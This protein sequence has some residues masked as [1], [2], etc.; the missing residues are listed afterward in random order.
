MFIF[1]EV[2]KIAGFTE[3]EFLEQDKS[4]VRYES[5][6]KFWEVWKNSKAKIM[7]ILGNYI[8]NY[9]KLR[10]WLKMSNAAKKLQRLQKLQSCTK[11]V[12][13]YWKLENMSVILNNLKS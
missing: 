10:K 8:D 13:N 4:F 12:V 5:N 6:T 3:K 2:T 7:K 1:I 9:I 11:N